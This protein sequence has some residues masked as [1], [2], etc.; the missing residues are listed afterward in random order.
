M[1]RAGTCMDERRAYWSC[2]EP[3]NEECAQGCR[4]L[5]LAAAAGAGGQGGAGGA[6]TD[7]AVLRCPPLGSSCRSFCFEVVDVL[8]EQGLSIPAT[9]GASQTTT[10]AGAR[11]LALIDCLFDR[12]QSCFEAA[13]E[14]SD[15]GAARAAGGGGVSAASGSAGALLGALDALDS[16][17]VTSAW[18]DVLQACV[19]QQSATGSGGGAVP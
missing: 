16:A 7:A 14:P 10:E 12:A 15:A 18:T 5:E 4:D 1:P 9:G 8:A 3:L 17:G 6:G 13:S 2:E 19:V 11:A